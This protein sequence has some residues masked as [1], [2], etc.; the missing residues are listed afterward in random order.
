MLC[1]I[2]NVMKSASYSLILIFLFTNLSGCFG[3]D[4][5]NWPERA[6]SE[7][8]F[9]FDNL[10]CE[11]FTKEMNYPIWGMNSPNNEGY[12]IADQSGVIVQFI[13]STNN[14]ILDISSIISRC[15][16][17]QGLLGFEFTDNFSS[18]GLILLSY[19]EKGSCDGD[20]K[21][22]LI[23]SSAY[24]DGEKIDI[25]SI[26]RLTSVEQPYRNHNGGHLVSIGNN[27]FLWGI[28]DGGSHA[29]PHSNGQ[30]SENVLGSIQLFKFNNSELLDIDNDG[31]PL[32]KTLHHGLRN[33]WRFD[34]NNSGHLWVT[35][36]GQNCWEEINLVNLYDHS[37]FG[38]SDKEGYNIFSQNS[39]SIIDTDLQNFT[40]PIYVYPHEN[41][42]CSITGG[43]WIDDISHPLN[44]SY[45][46]GDFCTGSI[47]LLKY[48]EGIWENELLS[49]TGTMITSFAEGPSGEILILT[50][51]GTVYSLA[52]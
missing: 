28:G 23:L 19:I 8:D 39:C 18:D 30:N 47:W 4:S 21:A 46:F 34:V 33:P 24:F 36:V 37:N 52:E 42:N 11:I 43:Y 48:Q 41:G 29:D 25:N 9:D 13:N 7:C 49:T 3:D 17:E 26:T 12:W 32:I 44:N 35:D 1:L 5:M 14:T 22:D 50:W 2:G 38:W 40:D 16:F 45:I 10:T 31:T 51:G 20:N 27:S 6:D 15:H